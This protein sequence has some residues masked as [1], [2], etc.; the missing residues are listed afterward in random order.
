MREFRAANFR[1]FALVTNYSH[2]F[3]GG[4]CGAHAVSCWVARATTSPPRTAPACAVDCSGHFMGHRRGQRTLC[5]AALWVA[6]GARWRTKVSLGNGIRFVV[7]SASTDR[8][9]SVAKRARKTKR[10]A[11][12]AAAY[13]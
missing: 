3:A 8:G 1:G 2:C 10:L 11:L 5:L 6:R 9:G 12:L 13:P 4:T 7:G